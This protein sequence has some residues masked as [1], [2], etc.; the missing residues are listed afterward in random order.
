MNTLFYFNDVSNLTDFESFR[1]IPG[2]AGADRQPTY[3]T[4]VGRLREKAVPPDFQEFPVAEL[5]N[6]QYATL[7]ADL[8][9]QAVDGGK[10]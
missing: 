8:C 4:V 7:F 10:R 9:R 3:W 2:S 5:P 6:E 1:V